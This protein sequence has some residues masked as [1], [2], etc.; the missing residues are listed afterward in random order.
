[1]AGAGDDDQAEGEALV[2]R[3]GE[4]NPMTG[5]AMAVRPG[6]DV[7]VAMS[8]ES[9]E[10]ARTNADSRAALAGGPAPGQG[11]DFTDRFRVRSATAEG[12][13]VLL[14]LEPVEGQYV[15][16]DLT[17]GPVLFATC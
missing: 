14:D 2:E 7:R 16:S 4:V 6:G 5:F 8:F 9:D 3:A 10:Q 17:S 13:T 12:A 15:L 1:M 11:G